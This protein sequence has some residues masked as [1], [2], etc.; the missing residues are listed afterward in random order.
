M[1]VHFVYKEFVK[2]LLNILSPSLRPNSQEKEIPC[3]IPLI[4]NAPDHPR[5]LTEMYNK[6]N[7][8]MPVN[9]ASILQHLEQRV[10]SS[11][12]LGNTFCKAIAAIDSDFSDGSGQ[13]QLKTF[14][15]GFTT[16]H[17]TKNIPRSWED[18]KISTFTG[19]WK[20]FIPVLMGDFEG[21]KTSVKQVT[22][23][24]VK[25]ARELELEVEPEDVTELL[26]I[27]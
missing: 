15:K 24:V 27:P 9:I 17:A 1:T 3:I 16:L 4:D 12:Y 2:Q 14:W 10:I 19:Y 23:V 20:K 18:V 11:H 13:S 26:Q 6:I 22:A 8:F 25:I 5:A 21:F 7:V